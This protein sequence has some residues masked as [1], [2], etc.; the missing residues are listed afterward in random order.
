MKE[1]EIKT[2]SKKEDFDII[3]NFEVEANKRKKMIEDAMRDLESQRFKMKE[4][5]Q[6]IQEYDILCEE[7][8][9]LYHKYKTVDK[10]FKKYLT[11]TKSIYEEIDKLKDTAIDVTKENQE[12]RNILTTLVRKVG[13][14]I[15]AQA[16][17]KKES[18]LKKYLD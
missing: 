1:K 12:L 9:K 4:Y 17:N 14:D 11:T 18:E 2:R 16:A 6:K 3:T 15:V 8:K 10:N 5:S 7:Y 13:I